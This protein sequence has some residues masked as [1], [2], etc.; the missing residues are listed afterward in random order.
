MKTAQSLQELTQE[1]CIIIKKEFT[2]IKVNVSALTGRIFHLTL[3]KAMP[4]L[5]LA[6][7]TLL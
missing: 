1:L 3:T 5:N 4:I 6:I 2:S 7:I